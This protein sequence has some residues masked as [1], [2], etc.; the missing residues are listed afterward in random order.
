MPPAADDNAP[1]HTARSTRTWKED[2]SIS[3]L[4]WPAIENLWDELDRR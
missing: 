1:A 2:N 4:P 3:A